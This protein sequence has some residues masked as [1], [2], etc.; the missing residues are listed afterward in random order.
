[1]LES[2][3][4]ELYKVGDLVPNSFI[5]DYQKESALIR[6]VVGCSL[7]ACV[8]HIE[9]VAHISVEDLRGILG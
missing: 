2:K 4:T 1:V 8:A 6:V 5:L 3:R 7:K 9:E